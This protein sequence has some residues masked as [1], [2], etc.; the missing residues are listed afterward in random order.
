MKREILFRGKRIDNG[1]WEEGMLCQ[2]HREVAAKI[3]PNDFGAFVSSHAWVVDPSTVGQY[4]GLTDKNGVKI[5]EG[6]IVRYIDPDSQ[7]FDP[8]EKYLAG[9]DEDTACIVFECFVYGK[10]IMYELF[11]KKQA[12]NLEIIG[13]KGRGDFHQL[14]GLYKAS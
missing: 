10:P 5:F 12:K 3:S 6:D 8:G 14:S 1:N 7:E 4:T 11:D 2:F 13:N 9:W